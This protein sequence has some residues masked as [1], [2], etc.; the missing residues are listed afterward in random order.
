MNWSFYLSSKN[1]TEVS[2][3]PDPWHMKKTSP[4]SLIWLTIAFPPFAYVGS[5]S[6]HLSPP[7]VSF[8]QCSFSC[9]GVIPIGTT[10]RYC[11]NQKLNGVCMPFRNSFPLASCTH[12]SSTML[13]AAR[14]WQHVCLHGWLLGFPCTGRK[15]KLW[16]GG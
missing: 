10:A 12:L 15:R 16:G 1:N 5:S 9:H 4:C 7:R 13:T 2:A 14:Q 3:W 8:F 6:P 11:L